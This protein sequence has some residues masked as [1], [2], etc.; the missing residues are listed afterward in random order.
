MGQRR[1]NSPTCICAVKSLTERGCTGKKQRARAYFCWDARSQQGAPWRI[2]S[3]W[4]DGTNT[5]GN[6]ERGRRKEDATGR[7]RAATGSASDAMTCQKELFG[8]KP[9]SLGAFFSKKKS[10]RPPPS[11][12]FGS[13][14]GLV[15]DLSGGLIEKNSAS[16]AF[17]KQD[18]NLIMSQGPC[19]YF[20]KGTCR[21]GNAC[22]FSH[23]M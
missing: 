6:S 5:S 19:I 2:T 8:R 18:S 3:A 1:V 17:H 21:N 14:S 12:S 4:E 22:K 10:A 20:A 16:A 7:R 13:Q 9:R 23:G 15:T 11:L